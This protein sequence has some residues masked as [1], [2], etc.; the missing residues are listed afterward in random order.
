MS[1][2]RGIEVHRGNRRLFVAHVLGLR[3]GGNEASETYGEIVAL[4][5]T[6]NVKDALALAMRNDNTAQDKF[7]R[8]A[9]EKNLPI[10]DIPEQSLKF[11]EDP[12]NKREQRLAQLIGDQRG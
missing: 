5:K 8:W 1:S 6:Q 2:K 10:E 3:L 7:R 9:F 11:F 12:P 4:S